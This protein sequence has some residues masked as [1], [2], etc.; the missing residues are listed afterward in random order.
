VFKTS[1]LISSG[2]HIDCLLL[3]YATNKSKNFNYTIITAIK[4]KNTKKK[5]KHSK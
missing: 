3:T 2:R 5:E 1:F 4:E